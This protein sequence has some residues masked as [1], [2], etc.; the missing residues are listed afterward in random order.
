MERFFEFLQNHS[1]LAG[2]FALLLFA[3]LFLESKRSG[4]KVSPQKLGLLMNNEDA[5]V[6]DLRE[7]KDFLAGHISGSENI[8]FSQLNAELERLKA[9]S[10]PVVMV[11]KMGTHAGSA[12][13]QLGNNNAYRLDGG[14][15][16]WQSQ[17]LPLVKSGQKGQ[18]KKKKKRA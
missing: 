9:L 15:M 10:V 17:G 13:Q 18:S 12:V 16:T 5:K 7:R 8:P 2:T 4:K 1:L 11:C 6:I 3:F 14:I